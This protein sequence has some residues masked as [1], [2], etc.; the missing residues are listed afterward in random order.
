MK[1]TALFLILIFALLFSSAEIVEI[2]EANFMWIWA[3]VEPVPGTI[4]PSISINNPKNNTVYS[5]NNIT[6][7]FSVRTAELDGWSSFIVD[8]EYS[9]DGSNLIPVD[10]GSE[11]LELFD[12]ALNLTLL[13]LGTHSLTVTAEVVVHRGEPLEKFLLDTSSTVYF[14]IDNTPS[15]P[16]P[17]PSPL[18][19]PTPEP[20]P[21]TTPTPEPT[22][23]PESF[24]AS[25]V[26]ASSIP[27]TVILIGL[28]L[29]VY[30]I[31]RK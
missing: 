1:K 11:L 9:L 27:V 12:T 25:L 22:I 5:S 7:N 24:P 15:S 17:S 28:G 30:L 29:L 8:V 26:I 31:K 19:I 23:E 2:A 10:K 14:T 13:P 6:L 21:T 3:T 18:S 20:I 4:P 16:S